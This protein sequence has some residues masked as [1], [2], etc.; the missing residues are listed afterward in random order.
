M[1]N[2]HGRS[3]ERR[4]SVPRIHPIII[5][6]FGRPNLKDLQALYA[7]LIAPLAADPETYARPITVVNQQTFHNNTDWH[8]PSDPAFKHRVEE[9]GSFRED[10]IKPH[11]DLLD[12]WSVDT[13][14]MWLAGFGHAYDPANIGHVYWLIPG[15]FNYSSAPGLHV[16]ARLPDMPTLVRDR[17]YDLILGEISVPLN[18]SKQLIDTYGTYGL[19][20]NWFPAEAQGLRT[21]T[22]KPRSEFFAISHTFL[23]SVLRRRWYPYEQTIVILLHGM[24]GREPQ[25]RIHKIALGNITDLEDT[26]D[27]LSSAMQQVERTERVLKL[28]WREYHEQLQDTTWRETFRRLDGQSQQIRAAALVIL[29]QILGK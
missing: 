23:D 6:P 15:D 11:S 5:Y 3:V 14:Q 7:D 9:F 4:A 10:Y 8:D 20:Y 17:T 13:C 16:L 19:L 25:R 21:I 24:R 2:D 28:Y 22:D 18:S 12:V 26:R 1:A 27:T 29:E